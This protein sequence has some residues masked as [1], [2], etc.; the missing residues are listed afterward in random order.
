MARAPAVAAARRDGAGGGQPVHGRAAARD[1]DRLARAGR[2][3]RADDDGGARRRSWRWRCS[4][5]AL[6]WAL[7]RMGA[8]YDRAIGR[9]AGRRQT[10]WLKPFNSGSGSA[11]AAGAARARHDPRGRG[12]ARRAR[13]RGVVLL[14]RGVVARVGVR[15]CLA[16]ARERRPRRTSTAALRRRVRWG[17]R[18]RGSWNRFHRPVNATRAPNLAGHVALT[19]MYAVNAPW[20]PKT[21]VDVTLTGTKRTRLPQ[22]RS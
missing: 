18:S 10:T 21:R 20:R 6:V 13:V 5:A 22:C 14:L 17:W 16:A 3:G 2:R 19:A 4:A 8:A 12:R 7:N 15:S 1:L 9:P 11:Q